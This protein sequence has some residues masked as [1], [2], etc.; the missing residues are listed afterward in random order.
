MVDVPVVDNDDTI[1]K[2]RVERTVVSNFPFDVFYLVPFAQR[3]IIAKMFPWSLCLPPHKE[4]TALIDRLVVYVTETLPH[5]GRTECETAVR[6]NGVRKHTTIAKCFVVI[7]TMPL[8]TTDEAREKKVKLPAYIT[9]P[10]HAKAGTKANDALDVTSEK[11]RFSHILTDDTV[12]FTP[13]GPITPVC[14][15]CPRHLLHVMNKCQLGCQHCFDDF[16]L[17]GGTVDEQLQDNNPD[18]DSSP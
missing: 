10:R 17:K 3:H 11:G 7:P 18:P 4:L 6:S 1:I 9:A 14:R 12:L 13:E 15:A 16:I 2:L 5:K 8:A